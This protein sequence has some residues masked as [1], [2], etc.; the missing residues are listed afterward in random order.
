MTS[1]TVPTDL[2]PP[3]KSN[4]YVDSFL[5]AVIMEPSYIYISHIRCPE[6][7]VHIPSLR[8]LSK[9]HMNPLKHAYFLWSGVATLQPTPKLEEHTLSFVCD[10]LFKIIHG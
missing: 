3:T 1:T 4:L 5:K 9:G 2:R 8:S 10:C 6:P 7:H